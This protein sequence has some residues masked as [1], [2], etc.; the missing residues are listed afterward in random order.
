M[1][2]FR[3]YKERVPEA[4]ESD[5]QKYLN[6][7]ATGE[8]GIIRIPPAPIDAPELIF[9]DAHAAR[10]GC[11]EEDAQNYVK[12]AYCTIYKKRW[13]GVSANYYSAYGAAYIDVDAKQIKTSFPRSEYD[14]HT[15]EVVEVFE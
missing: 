11:T 12:N 9:R 5:F 7:K 8:Q 2:E 13:D 6:V 1:T 10:H 3:G 14:P 4:S 15:K